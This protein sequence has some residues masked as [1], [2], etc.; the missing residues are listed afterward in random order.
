LPLPTD[1]GEALAFY[2][3]QGRPQCSTRRV[4]VRSRAPHR[5]FAS[6]VA[7]CDIVRR[8]LARAGLQPTHK[9]AHILRYS[10]ATKMLR[11]GASLG[12]IGE[13][14]RHR[15]SSSTEIYAKVDFNEL[16]KL[17]QPWPVPGGER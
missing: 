8:A 3:R 12:E 14:L 16:S 7:I 5:G 15:S 13:V 1:V 10:L 17:A 6:A 11:Q 2:L 9:G 4:F